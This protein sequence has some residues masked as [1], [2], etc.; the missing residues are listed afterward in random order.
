MVPKKVIVLII[1]NLVF[2]ASLSG[3]IEAQ[4]QYYIGIS[5]A[6]WDHSTLRILLIPQKEESWWNSAFMDSTV[7]A[8]NMWNDALATFA[9]L[10]QDFAYISN[11]RL[12]ST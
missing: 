2:A 10:Y 8:I 9:S 5:E 1:L 7:Q 11:L 3:E 6:T 12:N 4:T